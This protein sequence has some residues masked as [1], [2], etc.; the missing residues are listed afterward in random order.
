MNVEEYGLR[1]RDHEAI[2]KILL[3]DGYTEVH[4]WIDALAGPFFDNGCPYMHWVK[5]HNLKALR[6]KYGDQ[7][8]PEFMAGLL[9][10]QCDL[11]S[12]FRTFTP[13]PKTESDV[14]KILKNKGHWIR[15][16]KGLLDKKDD[17]LESGWKRESYREELIRLAK[18]KLEQ[19]NSE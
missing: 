15:R 12:H 13:T 8:S 17:W 16:C 3:G 6:D 14:K 7:T 4:K 5:R 11:L 18:Q 9:H 2:T 10:I 1:R 19:S